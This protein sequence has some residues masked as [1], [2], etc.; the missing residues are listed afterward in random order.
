M[1]SSKAALTQKAYVSSPQ[2]KS[3][4]QPCSLKLLL[5]KEPNTVAEILNFSLFGPCHGACRTEPVPPAV[6]A[7]S[8]SHGTSREYPEVLNFK[9]LPWGKNDANKSG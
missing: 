2:K 1:I 5:I 7:Q 4:A 3:C 8:S 6:E 9:C